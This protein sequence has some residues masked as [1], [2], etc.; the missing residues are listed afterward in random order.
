[1]GGAATASVLE[2]ALE[3][4]RLG[5][6]VLPVQPGGKAAVLPG[7]QEAASTDADVI[8]AWW[9]RW[10]RANVAIHTGQLVVLDLDRGWD[11]TFLTPERK[12]T[13]RELNPPVQRTPSAGY[14]IVFRRPDGVCWRQSAGKLGRGV[15][16]KTGP[17][18]IVVAPSQVGGRLYRW[19][20]PLVPLVDLPYPPQWL[21][22]EL[23]RL[24]RPRPA[25]QPVAV[26]T[27][28]TGIS[29]PRALRELGPIPEGCRH[30]TL[31]RVLAA[32]RACG[33]DDEQIEQFA[34]NVNTSYC[35]PPLPWGEVAAIIR[36]IQA[37]PVGPCKSAWRLV[38]W[39]PIRP[40]GL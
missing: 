28:T 24:Y 30:A 26:K 16:L 10:P 14:H 29:L 3:Y 33:A 31:L 1:M 35:C 39:T 34:A 40:N 8:T 4:G 11:E 22:T 20:R 36:W 27:F 23:D 25:S 19:V 21:A 6:R 9:R 5:F 13:L 15:D 7:W 17:A 12:Q 38:K 18:Y 37:L 2:A 32:C